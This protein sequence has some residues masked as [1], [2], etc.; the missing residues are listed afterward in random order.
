MT[1]HEAI[2]NL[3]DITQVF[4]PEDREEIDQMFY[5]ELTLDEIRE[6]LQDFNCVI[7]E[8]KQILREVEDGND[9]L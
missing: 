8:I 4:Q 7:G 3:K 2:L 9:K 1:E 5:N 6:N